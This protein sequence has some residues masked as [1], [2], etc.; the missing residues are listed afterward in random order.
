MNK[1]ILIFAGIAIVI[2]VIAGIFIFGGK[3]TEISE[4]EAPELNNQEIDHSVF[5]SDLEE[6]NQL[7]SELEEQ[8]LEII[9]IE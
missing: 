6:L 5:Q 8:D 7:D 1:K 2:L 3:K 4:N 9:E